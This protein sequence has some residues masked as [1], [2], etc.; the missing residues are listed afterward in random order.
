MRR[1]P[2]SPTPRPTRSCAA[3]ESSEA[4]APRS[5]RTHA[6]THAR[7]ER[8]SRACLKRYGSGMDVHGPPG[9]QATPPPGP[10]WAHGPPGTPAETWPLEPAWAPGPPGI[11]APAPWGPADGVQG[12]PSGLKH[13][14]GAGGSAMAI[15]AV[16]IPTAA[17]PAN[18]TG[19]SFFNFTFMGNWLPRSN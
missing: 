8:A 13:G 19:V 17:A 10:A 4:A 7:H 3:T 16:M 2:S 12:V 11:S 14:G 15:G 9:T 18:R 5:H 1:Q 6:A